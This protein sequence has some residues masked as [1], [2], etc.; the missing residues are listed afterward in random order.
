[1]FWKWRR[2][3]RYSNVAATIATV[4][5][6]AC[7]AASAANAQSDYPNKPVRII[8]PSTPGGGTDVVARLLAMELSRA[9]GQQFYIDNKAGASSL[10]GGA[11]AASS[12]PDGYTLLVAPSTMTSLHVAHAKMPFHPATDF[13]PVT[14]IVSIPD[15][16]LVNPSVPA[17][18]LQELLALARKS[19]GKLSYASPGFASTTGMGMELLKS[20]TGVDIQNVP[21]KGVA[22]AL[23]DVIAGRV[24][25]MMVNLASAKS[26]IDAGKLRP[27]AVTTSKRVAILPEVPTIAEQGVAGYDVYQW[28]GLL[29]PAGT[30]KP[31]VDM[32]YVQATKALRASAFVKWAAA[33]GADPV[34][35]TPAEF[36]T[37]IVQEVARWTDVASA[38]HIKPR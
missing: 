22:P 34:G 38:A 16:L 35:N 32:L 37:A 15:V 12:A 7:I 36:H 29:A 25:I 28:F 21:Y 20:R 27:I 9:I 13:A 23:I 17:K 31:I 1:M 8:V 26:Y 33:E 3:A 5:F 10:I 19:P 14:M 30:P 6:A 11:A 2:L 18:N 4:C 24:G